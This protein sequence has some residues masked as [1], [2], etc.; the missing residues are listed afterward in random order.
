MQEDQ[1]YYV[2]ESKED[3]TKL[4][5]EGWTVVYNEYYKDGVRRVW[6]KKVEAGGTA[7][8]NPIY[9]KEE[10]AKNVISE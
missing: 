7:Y 9:S 3:F 5:N 1:G 10:Y 4:L 8:M 6:M 2:A